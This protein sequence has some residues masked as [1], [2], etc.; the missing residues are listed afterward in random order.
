MIGYI[1]LIWSDGTYVD[2]PLLGDL[3]GV[4][5]EIDGKTCRPTSYVIQFFLEDLHLNQD[6]VAKLNLWLGKDVREAIYNKEK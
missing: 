2:Y 3:T 6:D 4:V 5:K 1:K